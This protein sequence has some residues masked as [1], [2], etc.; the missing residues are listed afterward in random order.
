MLHSYMILYGSLEIY[1]YHISMQLGS[2]LMS[3]LS[4]NKVTGRESL[5]RG[6]LQL[7]LN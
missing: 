4:G 1:I 6:H 7:I 5:Y 3:C 2:A